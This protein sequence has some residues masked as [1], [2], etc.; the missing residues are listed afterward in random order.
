MRFAGVAKVAPT[1]VPFVLDNTSPNIFKPL[2]SGRIYYF[3][4]F[5]TKFIRGSVPAD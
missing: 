5:A 2:I 3:G 1:T 4:L